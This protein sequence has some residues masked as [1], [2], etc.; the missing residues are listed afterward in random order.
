M[1]NW[2][3]ISDYKDQPKKKKKKK[4]H[5]NFTT[6]NPLPLPSFLLPFRPPI[7]LYSRPVRFSYLL[8]DY[9]E[10]LQITEPDPS[11]FN[12]SFDSGLT[13]HCSSSRELA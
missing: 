13:F 4:G 11:A 10:N 3:F 12:H 1:R 2:V 9:D 8:L 7:C 5:N 6:V